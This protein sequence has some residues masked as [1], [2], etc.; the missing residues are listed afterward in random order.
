MQEIEQLTKAA[1]ASLSE[2]AVAAKAHDNA[3]TKSELA[4][5]DIVFKQKLAKIEALAD[6][7]LK[8]T[9]KA[10]KKA[11]A[12]FDEKL[13]GRRAARKASFFG[14]ATASQR[15]GAAVS[16]GAFP[17]LFGGG[18]GMAL[19]GAIG[20]AA[21]G[22]TFG[23]AAIALQVLGGALD[24][25]VAK[26]AA[27][28]QALNEL[29]FNFDTVMQAAGLAGTA[30]ASY[31]TEIE[32]LAGATEAQELATK[33]L[34][35]RIGDEAVASLR[36]LGESTA[37]LGREFETLMTQL[38]AAIGGL[39]EPVARF[40]ANA[41][42]QGNL[43]K[44]GR[45]NVTK[46]PELDRLLAQEQQAL[47]GRFGDPTGNAQKLQDIQQQIRNRQLEIEQSAERTLEVRAKTLQRLNNEKSLQTDSL[48]V[49]ALK[50]Q[51]VKG[52]GTL[53]EENVKQLKKQIFQAEFLE[54]RQH[55]INRAI[56]DEISFRAAAVAIETKRVNLEEALAALNK[57]KDPAKP[58]K[59]TA[60][61]TG[62][63]IARRLR[64]QIAAYE[65]LDPFARQMAVIEAERES[66]Q[67]RINKVKDEELRKELELAANKLKGLKI[68]KEEA[69]IQNEI[70]NLQ[71]QKEDQANAE[72]EKLSNRIDNY[73]DQL[74][75]LKAIAN[76]TEDRVALE[77]QLKNAGTDIDRN[78]IRQIDAQTKLNER[79]QQQKDLFDQ[80]GNSI[81]SGIST[82][83]QSVINKTE[84]L[85]D[86]V[87]GVLADIGNMLLRLGIETAVKAG[88]SA[89]TSGGSSASSS[90]FAGVPNTTL[91][92]VLP[93]TFSYASGGYVGG[94]TRA[95]IGEGGQGEYVIPESKMR[96]SMARYS[97]GARGSS[98]I[99]ESGESGTVGGDGGGTAIAAPIDVRYTVERINDVEYVTAAQFQA[100]MQQAAAQGAQRGEQQTLR[101]LQMSGSTRRRIGL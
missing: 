82:A 62:E 80:I 5:D 96:E 3:V 53:T 101:R 71:L 95:L 61:E 100:G 16:A 86:A 17:L 59:L 47:T 51:L 2:M 32:K 78:Y 74:K 94:P 87:K 31:I 15:A 44:A 99:P 41:L 67:E 11:L 70:I 64:E 57:P 4:N 43:L 66:I 60:E 7:E 90:T 38:G 93:T 56:K 92:T 27:T 34:A 22:A 30:T 20:G 54:E 98:V 8:A 37:D 81:A 19:G 55:L 26:T 46:D 72:N 6:A 76:G 13:K 39:V 84:S 28:G 88:F 89:L 52:Q 21:A 79:I 25:F 85:G 35:I 10:D 42:K 33:A 68:A 36:E 29:T 48:Q 63:G 65:E 49:L 23:P 24:Q 45:T 83:L 50:N 77:I 14:D 1:F 9:K 40:A 58:R 18:P 97:R 75:L 69:K 91:N 73:H 12:D